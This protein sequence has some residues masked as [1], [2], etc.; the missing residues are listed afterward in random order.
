[1][2]ICSGRAGCLL[3][4]LSSLLPWDRAFHWIRRTHCLTVVV[5]HHALDSHPFS[6]RLGVSQFSETTWLH[7]PMLMWQTCSGTPGLLLGYWGFEFRS[8]CLQSKCSYPLSLFLSP[9]VFWVQLLHAHLNL[10][11]L[12]FKHREHIFLKLLPVLVIYTCNPRTEKLRQDYKFEGSLCFIAS[13]RL[14]KLHSK[15]LSPQTKGMGSSMV[16]LLHSMWKTRVWSLVMGQ[17]HYILML[18]RLIHLFEM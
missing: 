6:A 3:L 8:L 5:R 12:S 15:T 9:V 18:Q 1:M 4:L 14:S 17:N 11:S 2:C 10:V 7:L 16:E 13:S